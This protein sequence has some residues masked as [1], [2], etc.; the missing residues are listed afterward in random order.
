LPNCRVVLYDCF[1]L[2]EV[3]GHGKDIAMQARLLLSGLLLLGFA[4]AAPL[5]A[6]AQQSRL[7]ACAEEWKG[8]KAANQTQGKTYRQF[9]KECLSRASAAAPSAATPS[10]ATVDAPK[11]RGKGKAAK[12]EAAAA[13]PGVPAAKSGRQAAAERR[14]ACGAEWKGEKEAGKVATGMTWPKYWSACNKRKKAEG[15]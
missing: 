10:A 7:K 14:R 11:A 1:A 12:D 9:T 13:Q 8:L 2:V 3:T 4:A 5:P 6:H 15:A